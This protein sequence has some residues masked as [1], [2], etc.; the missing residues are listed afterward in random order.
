M[1]KINFNINSSFFIWLAIVIFCL[2]WKKRMKKVFKYYD[3]VILYFK[4]RHILSIIIPF[5]FLFFCFVTSD[6]QL[7]LLLLI[8][9]FIIPTFIRENKE[10]S[11]AKK[12]K[13]IVKNMLIKYKKYDIMLMN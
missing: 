5:F 12:S 10:Y 11:F 8:L 4:R 1:S 9:I 2:I 3:D 13:K 7:W 6:Y